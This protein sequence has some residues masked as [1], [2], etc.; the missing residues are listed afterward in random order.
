RIPACRR[1]VMPRMTTAWSGRVPALARSGRTSPTGRLI[2]IRSVC[3]S[4]LTNLAHA[5]RRPS[6]NCLEVDAIVVTNQLECGGSQEGLEQMKGNN[7]RHGLT[8]L[9]PCRLIPPVIIDD[10][11]EVLENHVGSNPVLDPVTCD[12]LV[13]MVQS[14]D[15]DD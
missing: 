11:V 13:D 4:V 10:D 7:V 1:S 6:V 3:S 9:L 12:S 5:A 14:H 2:R 15:P 8:A